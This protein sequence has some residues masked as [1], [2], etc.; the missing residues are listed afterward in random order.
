MRPTATGTVESH[1]LLPVFLLG[2]LLCCEAPAGVL[3]YTVADSDADTVLTSVTV[4]TDDKPLFRTPPSSFSIQHFFR[5]LGTLTSPSAP[6]CPYPTLHPTLS[7]HC[8]NRPF[9]LI[10]DDPITTLQA[11]VP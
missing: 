9:C 11:D 1:R 3:R 8:L 10:S 7:L 4:S 2:A 6:S 5:H